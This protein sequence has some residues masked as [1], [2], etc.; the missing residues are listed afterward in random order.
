MMK[1]T[2]TQKTAS[3]LLLEHY[4]DYQ[5]R[6]GKLVSLR[7]FAEHL[8]V[9]VSTISLLMSGKRPLSRSMAK[10]LAEAAN[11]PRFYDAAG[12]SRPDPGLQYITQSWDRLSESQRNAIRETVAR[13]ITESKET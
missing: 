1:I 8:G 5:R 6:T 11:D 4:L 7:A 10:R 9:H 3:E 13:Y 12:L 2:M